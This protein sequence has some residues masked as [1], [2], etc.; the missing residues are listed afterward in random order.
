MI[1]RLGFDAVII[2]T[3]AAGAVLQPGNPAFGADVTAAE[4]RGLIGVA[5]PIA[6]R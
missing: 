3:L 4:L 5:S 2:D 6:P 1:D